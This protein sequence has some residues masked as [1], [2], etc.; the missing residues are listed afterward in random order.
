MFLSDAQK[1]VIADLKNNHI[2]QASSTEKKKKHLYTFL[3]INVIYIYIQYS[4]SIL[5]SA[6]DLSAKYADSD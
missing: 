5:Q 3:Y 6:I 4:I 1:T 2:K